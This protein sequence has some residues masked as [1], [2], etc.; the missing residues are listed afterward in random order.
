MV[1]CENGNIYFKQKPSYHLFRY[2]ESITTC[3][4]SF[5]SCLNF[6][7]NLK[8]SKQ[9]PAFQSVQVVLN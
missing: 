8:Y 2:I 7:T 3:K 9:L 4:N 1:K 5:R 6:G